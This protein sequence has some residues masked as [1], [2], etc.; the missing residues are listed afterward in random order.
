MTVSKTPIQFV[1]LP[2][3]VA[4]NRA[5]TPVADKPLTD[6]IDKDFAV[7]KS[8]AD[9]IA[10][11]ATVTRKTSILT[12]MPNW[13]WN[14]SAGLYMDGC[15]VGD[16]CMLSILAKYQGPTLV[17]DDYGGIANQKIGTLTDSKYFPGG[18]RQL[19]F[20]GVTSRGTGIFYIDGAGG[21]W[22]EGLSCGNL[23]FASGA[24]ALLTCMYI[25]SGERT[26]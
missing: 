17:A 19:H 8:W 20:A 5:D 24:F 12:L 9:A 15:R 25:P 3:Q 2:R 13:T 16:V 21:V 6:A 11:L 4:T 7:L 18:T 22:L 26:A 10:T 1:D 23:T 14:S